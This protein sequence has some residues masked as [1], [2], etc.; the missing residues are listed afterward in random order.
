MGGERP[1][2]ICPKCGRQE[3]ETRGVRTTGS[4]LSRWFNYQ[5]NKF[6]VVS[7]AHCGYSEF[8]YDDGR[9]EAEAVALFGSE[10]PSEQRASESGS[11]RDEARQY[12]QSAGWDLTEHEPAAGIVLFSGTRNGETGLF[13]V[14]I[15]QTRQVT[16]SLVTDFETQRRD[17]GVDVA[18]VTTVGSYTEDARGQLEQYGIEQI[19]PA[20]ISGSRSVAPRRSTAGGAEPSGGAPP[21][22]GASGGA[23]ADDSGGFVTRRRLLML[24]GLLPATWVGTYAYSQ[25]QPDDAGGP[26]IESGGGSIDMQVG[27]GTTSATSEAIIVTVPV[28]NIGDSRG[29]VEFRTTLFLDGD[30]HSTNRHTVTVAGGEGRTIESRHEVGRLESFTSESYR[31]SV[32]VT[33]EYSA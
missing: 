15:D 33:D 27:R 30:R 23:D 4:G 21:P 8:Y 1:K 10:R 20:E 2:R 11:F 14:G 6:L 16:E 18:A 29:T 9:D 19:P 17:R 26:G 7:C 25:T 28:E 13:L 24:L 32:N 5:R 22:S 31:H 12:W 3:I